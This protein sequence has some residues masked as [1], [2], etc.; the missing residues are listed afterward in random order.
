M[1]NPRF[2]AIG[3]VWLPSSGPDRGTVHEGPT[4]AAPHG[5]PASR[6]TLFVA[7]AT[8]PALASLLLPRPG[9]MKALPSA[10]HVD[11]HREIDGRGGTPVWPRVPL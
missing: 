9:G 11:V 6:P 7:A 3:P 5:I 2:L 8:I 1:E 10:F 4:Q